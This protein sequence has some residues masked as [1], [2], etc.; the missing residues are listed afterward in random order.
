MA[1]ADFF[2][3]LPGC[4]I[5]KDQKK[6]KVARLKLA[7]EGQTRTVYLKRYNASHGVTGWVHYFSDPV[8]SELSEG[9]PYSPRRAWV[10]RVLWPL[11]NQDPV[12]C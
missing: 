10:P 7:I 4:E 5:I 12:A 6:I 1:N 9:R 3:G 2:F 11:W 8:R